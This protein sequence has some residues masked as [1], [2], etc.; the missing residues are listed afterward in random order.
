MLQSKH[1]SFSI[2]LALQVELCS[3]LHCQQVNHWGISLLGCN[4]VHI[5]WMAYRSW[6]FCFQTIQFKKKLYFSCIEL[7][8]PPPPLFPPHLHLSPVSPLSLCFFFKHLMS[9]GELM[10]LKES[11]NDTALSHPSEFNFCSSTQATKTHF[12]LT[13][14]FDVI[15]L[16][17]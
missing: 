6:L 5:K 1:Q 7:T 11:D 8:V 2:T 16:N 14:E 10:K 4:M 17:P 15:N 13:I 3:C 9:H 12:N